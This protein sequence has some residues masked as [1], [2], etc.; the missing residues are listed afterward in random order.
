MRHTD[1]YSL[2]NPRLQQ[3]KQRKKRKTYPLPVVIVLG[4][5]ALDEV[6]DQ[7]VFASVA[8]HVDGRQVPDVCVCVS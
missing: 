7:L 1:C 4:E 8:Q 2:R 3:P 6:L 5:F